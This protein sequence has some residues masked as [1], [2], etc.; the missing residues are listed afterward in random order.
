MHNIAGVIFMIK[1]ITVIRKAGEPTRFLVEKIVLEREG[2]IGKDFQN[3]KKKKNLKEKSLSKSFVINRKNSTR[4][5]FNT[6]RPILK[7][8]KTG[9]I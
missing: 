7:Y 3:N 6:S 8:V 5:G 9:M 4:L 2:E 1:K